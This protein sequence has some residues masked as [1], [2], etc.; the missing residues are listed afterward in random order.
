MGPHGTHGAGPRVSKSPGL[1]L[2]CLVSDLGAWQPLLFYYVASEH[3]VQTPFGM[4]HVFK[5]KREGEKMN[6]ALAH[7]PDSKASRSFFQKLG[8]GAGGVVTII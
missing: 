1:R 4:P 3:S 7:L 8:V 6:I 5:M 2:S